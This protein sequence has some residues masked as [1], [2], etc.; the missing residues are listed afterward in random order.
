MLLSHHHGMP[1]IFEHA[2]TAYGMH[3]KPARS[4]GRELGQDLGFQELRIA[5]FIQYY[6]CS[7]PEHAATHGELSATLNFRL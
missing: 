7:G 3:S 6:L 1:E 5:C 4:D 2:S